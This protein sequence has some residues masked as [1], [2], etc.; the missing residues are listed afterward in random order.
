MLS[1]IKHIQPKL[2]LG[3]DVCCHQQHYPYSHHCYFCPQEEK[4]ND[5]CDND[6]ADD[7]D[8]DVHYLNH[9]PYRLT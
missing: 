9:K 3:S 7:D 4:D 8:D 6:D 5:A 2:S 1:L